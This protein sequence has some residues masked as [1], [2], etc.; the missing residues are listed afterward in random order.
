MILRRRPH[1]TTDAS[2]SRVTAGPRSQTRYVGAFGVEQRTCTEQKQGLGQRRRS[3]QSGPFRGQCVAGF[4][5]RQVA[6]R[7]IYMSSYLARSGANT[8]SKNL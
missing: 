4:Q 7:I 5:K 6:A 3:L 1:A 8:P 2:D